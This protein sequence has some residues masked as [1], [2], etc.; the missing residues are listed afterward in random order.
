MQEW[1]KELSKRRML[2]FFAGLQGLITQAGRE[3]EPDI[4]VF[5]DCASEPDAV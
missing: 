3:V 1:D 2:V 5:H 4:S